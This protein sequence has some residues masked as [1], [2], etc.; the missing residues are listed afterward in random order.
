MSGIALVTGGSG[1]IGSAAVRAL[2]GAGYKVYELS[3]REKGPDCAVH[4]RGD[5]SDEAQAE[6]A[7]RLVA[8]AEGRIDLLVNCAGFGISGAVEFT[9]LGDAKRQL[10]VNLYGAFLMSRAVIPYMRKSGGGRIINVSSVAACVP[11]PFQAWYS[12]SK[13]GINALTLALANELRPFNIGVCAVMPGDTCTGFTDARVK[14]PLGDEVYG[15]A[16]GR[17]VARMERDERNG[18]SP[19]AV[20]RLIC[21]IAQKKRLRP[22]YTVGFNYRLVVLL[23]RL[24]PWSLSNRIIG[25]L[26]AS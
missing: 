24:L 8:E 9:K 1:G 10:D 7:A 17:A 4:I 6:A 25:R 11:V 13:A 16:I 23:S 19:E 14:E 15:G 22:L 2:A 5:V 12:V 21:R 26:Y 18:A 20:G 3:R